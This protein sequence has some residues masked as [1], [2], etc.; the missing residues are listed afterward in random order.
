MTK[1]LTAAEHNTLAEYLQRMQKPLGHHSW[2]YTNRQ[3]VDC[4]NVKMHCY[5]DT[6]KVIQSLTEKEQAAVSILNIKVDEWC[7]QTKW[8]SIEID[9]AY[10]LENLHDAVELNN[11]DFSIDSLDYGGRSG[12]WLCVVF[13]FAGLGDYLEGSDYTTQLLTDKSITKKEFNT[14][15]KKAIA[16]RD[17]I[18]T[19]H[20][21]IKKEHAALCRYYE[22]VDTYTES[23]SCHI[24][25]CIDDEA[26]IIEQKAE[27]LRKLA[28]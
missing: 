1:K 10:L 11:K 20:E 14:W 19:V 6:N 16:A 26:A 25:D 4:V 3:S 24:S 18:D 15:E 21:Y 9:R 12:G 5:V 7:E 13:N 28:K 23:L 2:W 27:N 8:D 22:Q 17:Y